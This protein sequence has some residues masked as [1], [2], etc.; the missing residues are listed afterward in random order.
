MLGLNTGINAVFFNLVFKLLIGKVIK[1]RACY[2]AG[3]ILCDTELLCNCNGGVLMVARY[4][5]GAYACLP[6]LNNS[7]NN[8][9]TNRIYHT[10]KTDIAKVLF[11]KFGAFTFR[12][13]GIGFHCNAEN[14]KSLVCHFLVLSK[15]FLLNLICH[16]NSFAVYK[17]LRASAE[18]NIGS[19]LCVLNKAVLNRFMNGAHHFP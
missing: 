16:G 4:H 19:T 7:V 8:L 14:A 11:K 12:N 3:S 17:S 10:C 18:N 6:C 15:D 13:I 2:C 1:L 5:N 9:G